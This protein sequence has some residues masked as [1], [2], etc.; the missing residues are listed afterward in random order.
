MGI[1]E[2]IGEK[3]NPDNPIIGFILAVGYVILAI[4]LVIFLPTIMCFGNEGLKREMQSSG[5]GGLQIMVAI[6][7]IVLPV[8]VLREHEGGF[9]FGG[10]GSRSGKKFGD[11]GSA[12]KGTKNSLSGLTGADGIVLSSRVR[13]AADKSCEHIAIIGPTG[14]GKSSCF[15]I[16]NLLEMN[17]TWSAVVTDPKAEMYNLC[18]PYLRQ[19]GYDILKLAPLEEDNEFCYNPLL[20]ASNPDE[21]DTLSQVILTNGGKSVEQSTGSSSGGAEWI[22]MSQPLLSA[23]FIWARYCGKEKTIYEAIKFILDSNLETMEQEFRKNEAAYDK[24]LLFK[25]SSGSEKTMSSIKTT[26]ASNVQ[27]FTRA[28]TKRFTRTP[29]VITPDG[30]RKLDRSLLYDPKALREKPTIVFICCPETRSIEQM[31][32]MSVLYTQTLE[33]TM[34]H[35]DG[36]PIMFLLDEFANIGIIPTI[37]NIAATARSRRISLSLG[38]QGMEQLKENYGDDKASNLLNNLK[39]KVIFSGLTGE[40]AEYVSELTGVTTVETKSFSKNSGQGFDIIGTTSK[41]A[42]ATQRKLYTPDEIRRLPDDKVLIIAHNRDPVEDKKNSWF[43]LKKYQDKVNGAKEE[44][45]DEDEG[46]EI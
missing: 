7:A 26:L 32:L 36:Q 28:S 22:S 8:Y 35:K 17:G 30:R 19:Q 46:I 21:I 45:K 27:L 20:I 4:L 13:L 37:A 18:G 41:S 23:A 5:M 38:L 43:K 24:F 6:M 42:S 9:S 16:P 12:K 33:K 10:G 34:E 3:V 1:I 39:T 31:P 44:K 14:S 15:Y 2:K 29:F 25:T 40:S 11:Q